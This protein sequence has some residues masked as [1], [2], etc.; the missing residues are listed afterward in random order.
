MCTR[1]EQ[2][3]FTASVGWIITNLLLARKVSSHPNATEW[4]LRR[5]WVKLNDIDIFGFY[6]HHTSDEEEYKMVI[7]LLYRKEFKM[8]TITVKWVSYS[9]RLFIS[10]VD[11]LFGKRPCNKTFM[12]TIRISKKMKHKD[13]ATGN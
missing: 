12:G 11:W 8:L 13:T 3:T 1:S 9:E 5:Y 7:S 10:V 2:R 4:R 6:E